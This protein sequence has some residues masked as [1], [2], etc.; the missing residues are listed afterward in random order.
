MVTHGR[1]ERTSREEAVRRYLELR[2]IVRAHLTASV[3]ADLHKEFESITAHQLRAL[4]LLP[5]EGLSMRQLAAALGVM[6]A[7][8]SVLADRLVAQG[9]AVRL[10]DAADRRV[11]R[12]APSERGRS[13][14]ARAAA[15]QRRSAAEI[16]NRLNDVQVEAF[17]DVLETLAAWTPEA[18]DASLAT[19]SRV[20][21][22]RAAGG[23]PSDAA[24]RTAGSGRTRRQR[25]S[26]EAR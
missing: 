14:A 4:L 24:S 9:L 12:L 21:A 10:P 5:D 8:V 11:V 25:V 13:L 6:G 22:A 3:P 23:A 18:P 2:P 19:T 17:L 20:R 16:F 15:Q 26:V 7:T 1:R